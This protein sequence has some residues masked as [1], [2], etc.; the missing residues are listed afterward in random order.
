M[1]RIL[2]IFSCLLFYTAC[3]KEKADTQPPVLT[4]DPSLNGAG[5]EQG[6]SY[7]FTYTASD[8]K[9]LRD[10]HI[11]WNHKFAGIFTDLGLHPWEGEEV[12]SLV[13]KEQK[14]SFAGQVPADAQPG[15]YVLEATA[16]DV[17]GRKSPQITREFLVI[18]P[19]N[20]TAPVATLSNPAP[21]GMQVTAGQPFN[22]EGLVTDDDGLRIIAI[23]IVRSSPPGEGAVLFDKKLTAFNN[24]RLISLK[25][26]V[27]IPTTQ[28]AGTA[29]LYLMGVDAAD[30]T[31][32]LQRSLVIQ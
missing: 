17:D 15:L 7:Q 2:L 27:I 6:E 3:K 4:A 32:F 12:Q 29:I 30:N 25:E 11:S 21:G 5:F 19:R 1:R 28:S 22:I 24:P 26:P 16:S 18:N 8:D 14:V 9:N 13:G 10:L 31:A 23:K 20:L